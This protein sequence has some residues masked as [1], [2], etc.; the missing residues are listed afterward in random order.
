ML[1]KRN[2]RVAATA[3]LGFLAVSH[4]APASSSE[5][6]GGISISASHSGNRPSPVRLFF[7]PSD[8]GAS[9]H[10]APAPVCT[11]KDGPNPAVAADRQ[12]PSGPENG[13]DVVRYGWDGVWVRGGSS[14]EGG[15]GLKSEAWDREKAEKGK[16]VVLGASHQ[17]QPPDTPEVSYF[18]IQLS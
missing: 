17:Q 15:A 3:G 11:A 1:H 8:G 14:E 2:R 18:D 10:R 4:L 13:V 9:A 7:V 12:P 16:R 6:G 5:V